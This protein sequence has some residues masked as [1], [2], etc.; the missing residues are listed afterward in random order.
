MSLSLSNP[1]LNQKSK[2]INNHLQINFIWFE[3][4]TSRISCNFTGV[5]LTSASTKIH[6]ERTHEIYIEIKCKQLF[7][8][9]LVLSG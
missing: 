6:A 1:S 5:K 9:R 4:Y 8:N 2:L 3:N 7:S